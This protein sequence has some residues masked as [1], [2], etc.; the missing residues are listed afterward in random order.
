M[1]FV[2][3]DNMAIEVK[4]VKEVRNRDLKGLRAFCEEKSS[5][6]HRIIVSFEKK[7]R[8]IEGKFLV[9]PYKEFLKKL[10]KSV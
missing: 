1:D 9:L 4:P 2:I 7:T 8:L 10:W 6:K 5:F 3:G